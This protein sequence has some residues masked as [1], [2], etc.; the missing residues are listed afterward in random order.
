[1]DVKTNRSIGEVLASLE[2]QATL[3]RERKAF[4]AEHEGRHRDCRT[5]RRKGE[6]GLR[7]G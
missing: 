6:R 2:A 4:H 3:H 5:A 7:E 1:M